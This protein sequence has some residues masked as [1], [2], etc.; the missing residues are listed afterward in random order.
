MKRH[1]KTENTGDE[2]VRSAFFKRDPLTC[3]R[4][5][6]GTEL[7]WGQCSG[8]VVE[9]EAYAAIDDEAAHTF[10]RPSARSFI[11][12][13]KAGAAYVYFNYG[14]HWML[15]V[16]VKGD[17]NGFV[18]IR[19]LEPRRGVELMKR[20]RGV[21]DLRQL[22]S[23][24]GKLTQAF[25]ITG[26]DHEMDLCSDSRHCFVSNSRATFDVVA[27]KRIGIS[28]SAH[29]PWRFT[30]RGSEFVSRAGKADRPH[31]PCGRMAVRRTAATSLTRAPLHR[32][33]A[34]AKLQGVCQRTPAFRRNALQRMN[35]TKQRVLLGMSGG[36]DSSVA[37]Y[38]L[39]EQGYDVIG[40]T[41]KV[42]PQDCIS[43]AEDKC[44]G[45]QAVADA[46]GVAHALGIPHYVVDEADQ[47][48]RVVIDY[49]AS[50]YQAGRTPN[51]CVMCNE[52]LKFGNL[53]SKAAALGCDYIA[54]GHYAIIE[55]GAG[56]PSSR[57][58]RWRRG[59]IR[60]ASQRRRSAQGSVLFSI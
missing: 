24:P 32:N 42:W 14:V 21:N 49:F 30:L 27:D 55:H 15:N 44:C 40:V 28:R 10:T 25:A 58:R 6:I 26:R 43:R 31:S 8:L 60:R 9:V 39:R 23:G 52:K 45:P 3:A 57:S 5:L 37:G 16:L 2:I 11:E 34:S 56:T 17:A 1:E 13:N 7:I 29:L 22:C 20:R 18:L 38:L 47:F 51:P 48:E 54:T 12:R 46:R 59:S 4:E 41:M 19:A 36:V 50:E 53:W 35:K 33:S